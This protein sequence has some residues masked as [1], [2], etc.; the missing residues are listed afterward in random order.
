MRLKCLR[1]SRE[2][3]GNLREFYIRRAHRILPA[4]GIFVLLASVAYGHE[5]RSIDIGTM[6][7]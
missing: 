7:L 3:R 2:G 6:F 4:A 1:K 5:L